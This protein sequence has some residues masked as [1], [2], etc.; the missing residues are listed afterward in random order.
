MTHLSPEL[1]R[2][3]LDEPAALLSQ[4]KEHVLACATCR[5]LYDEI[6]EN[7]AFAEAAL[8]L[9]P[10]T[11]DLEAASRTIARRSQAARG[12][13]GS[14]TVW[15]RGG[16]FASV[17]AAAVVAI[18]LSFAPVRST[19]ANFLA[20]FEP[21]SFVPIGVTRSDLASLRGLPDLGAFGTTHEAS[22][23]GQPAIFPDARSA[24]RFIN[25]TIME[26]RYLPSQMGSG[27]M[28]HVMPARSVAFTF[29][30][31]K[32]RASAAAH[33]AVLPPMPARLD[34]STLYATIGPVALS[35][36]GMPGPAQTPARQFGGVRH[37]ALH[38]PF[39]RSASGAQGGVSLNM[40]AVV[41][42]PAP[43]IYST[44]AS[45]SE[46]LGYLMAQ[47][48][49]PASLAAQIRTIGDPT[50]TLPIPIVVDKSVA[51]RVWVQGTEG[52][53]IGDETGVGSVVIWQRGGMVYGVMGPYSESQTMAVANSL[54]P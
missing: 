5:R 24:G 33:H 43:R 13:A 1:L 35:L 32:A 21:H 6:G 22:R 51:Q 8:K 42:A 38:G 18:G 26:P 2:R 19:A 48:G 16:W 44:G 3:H 52:L 45:V 36:Y 25:G 41:Q 54:A 30:E 28:V 11:L 53:A 40:L 7:A 27:L 9:A 39:T 20:I 14:R 49:M 47:P 37:V 10:V 46:I 4:D 34:G 23:Q 29:D 12:T 50:T 31:A 15:V 17:A